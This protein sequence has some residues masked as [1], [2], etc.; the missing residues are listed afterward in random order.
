MLQYSISKLLRMRRADAPLLLSRRCNFDV[1]QR[2]TW[3]Q[4]GCAVC[5]GP[6][7]FVP[8]TLRLATDL[9]ECRRRTINRTDHP[10]LNGPESAAV[11][12]R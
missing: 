10:T 1:R 12:N 4:V 7:G 6:A 2:A 9:D 3:L 11:I 8:M 5:G